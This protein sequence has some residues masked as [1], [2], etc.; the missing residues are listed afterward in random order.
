MLVLLTC[1]TPGC[2]NSQ[3]PIPVEDP[4]EICACGVCGQL[5]TNK[6]V[7]PDPETPTT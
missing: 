1:E 5:I 3:I 4:S 6:L 7:V 2:G